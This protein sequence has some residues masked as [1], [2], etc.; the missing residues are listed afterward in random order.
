MD[1]GFLLFPGL[2]VAL[3]VAAAMVACFAECRRLTRVVRAT[4][5]Q[6][7]GVLADE[8][9]AIRAL[10][11]AAIELRG[12]ATTLLG[13][14]DRLCAGVGPRENRDSQNRDGQNRDGQN[15]TTMGA[16]IG[17]IAHQMLDLADD[18]QHHALADAA[19]RV[20]DEEPTR[21]AVVLRD[22]ITV[23]GSGLEPSRRQWL[24]PPDIDAIELLV[25]RR[26]LGQILVRV[27]G[28]AAR[29]S[30]L[31]D[32]ID[33]SFEVDGDH[34]VLIIADEGIGLVA[35]GHAGT[36][37]PADSRGLGLGLTLARVLMEA[38]GGALQV[39]AVPSVG[40]RVRLHFPMPRLLRMEQSAPAAPSVGPPVGVPMAG[41]AMGG[42]PASLPMHM[43]SGA[44][45]IET[46][47]E[48]LAEPVDIS[49][50][51]TAGGLPAGDPVRV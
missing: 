48:R 19:S 28:S 12:P 30:R 41:V 14:A 49:V 13:H 45:V 8:R 10:R 22:A 9:A 33:I 40:T 7:D 44:Q 15:G 43:E 31:D 47:G 36:P 17:A 29:F 35:A 34:F 11:L 27:L 1:P 25:D 16:T 23:V 5:A 21:L 46:M 42:M 39:E 3:L 50:S 26:A 2:A 4:E 37:G 6:R 38:H 32:W 51:I 20:L 24:L 18:M